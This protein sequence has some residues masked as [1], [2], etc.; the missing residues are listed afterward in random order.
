MRGEEEEAGEVEEEEEEGEGRHATCRAWARACG[1]L[2]RTVA[3]A[4]QFPPSLPPS[5]VNVPLS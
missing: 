3:S 1:S 4:F 5:S 2:S